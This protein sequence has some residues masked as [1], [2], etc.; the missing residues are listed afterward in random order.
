MKM[1]QNRLVIFALLILAILALLFGLWAGLL[2]L[3][4]ALPGAFSPL[5][6]DHGPLMVSGF[7]GTLIALER[8]VA[9]RRKWMFLGPISSGLG[10]AA[11]LVFPG[12]VVGP[13]LISLGSLVF[14]AI[15]AFMIRRETRIFTIVMGLGSLSWLMGNLLWLAG[16]PIFQLVVWWAAFLVLTVA[17]ERLE[18][19]RVL[20]PT[21]RQ[22]FLFGLAAAIFLGGVLLS[23][24]RQDEGTRLAG[25]GL[26]AIAVWLGVY[27]IARRN[28]RHSVPLTR[29]IAACLF[30]GYVWLG[31]SG[32]IALWVGRQFGGG[33]YDAFLH[34]VFIGFIISMIFGHAPIILPALTGQM[35]RF[36]P[37]FYLQ[38]VLLHASLVL[39]VFGDLAG[40]PV[41]RQWGGL[42]NEVAILLFLGIT[43]YVRFAHAAPD[44]LHG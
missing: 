15:L 35:V 13:L 9:I 1:K 3:G 29:Y 40:F 37:A 6:L 24:W 20:R 42:L 7:L 28:L 38:L 16:K 10:W 21:P 8:V 39:R 11:S 17:G 41:A 44:A 14:V 43:M 31:V 32:V 5:P 4:W 33:L 30:A 22:H 12:Q 34:T 26:L 18:L 23:I 2:R 25:A 19:S 27:D 36:H